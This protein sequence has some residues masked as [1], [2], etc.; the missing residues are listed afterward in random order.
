MGFVTLKK[1]TVFYDV[2]QKFKLNSKSL[3]FLLIMIS[4]NE[5]YNYLYSLLSA[6]YV[7][8]VD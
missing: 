6:V 3:K 1:I 2:S 7:V 5:L 4:C 8:H